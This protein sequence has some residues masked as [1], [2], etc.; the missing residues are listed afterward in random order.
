MCDYSHFLQLFENIK[1]CFPRLRTLNIR[2]LPEMNDLVTFLS[3]DQLIKGVA[4]SFIEMLLRAHKV[5]PIPKTKSTSGNPPSLETIAFGALIYRD[6]WD[7][8]ITD[9]GPAMNDYLRL[10][11]FSIEY[12]KS[13]DGADAPLLILLAKGF[14]SSCQELR[15]NTRILHPYWLA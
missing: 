5:D 10:R 2:N 4:S 9:R 1:S 15:R 14:S 8:T 12:L 3:V 6:V 11:T 13:K 7:G